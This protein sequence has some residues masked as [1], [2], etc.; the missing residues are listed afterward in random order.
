MVSRIGKIKNDE[1]KQSQSRTQVGVS[2]LCRD[3]IGALET[4]AHPTIVLIIEWINF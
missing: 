1:E 4:G 3:H 2:L